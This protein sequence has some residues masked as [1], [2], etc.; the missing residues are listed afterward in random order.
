M[1]ADSDQGTDSG[2][3]VSDPQKAAR[4]SI[5]DSITL[6]PSLSHRRV[7]GPTPDPTL[8]PGELHRTSNEQIQNKMT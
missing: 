5:Q 8:C 1:P 6:W 7:Q 4:P 2:H 3:H